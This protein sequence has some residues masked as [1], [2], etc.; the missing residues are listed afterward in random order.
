MRCWATGAMSRADDAADDTSAAMYVVSSNAPA[1]SRRPVNARPSRN[2]KRIWTPA[3]TTRTSW[4][5]SLKLRWQRAS[6]DSSPSPSSFKSLLFV[7][8]LRQRSVPDSPQPAADQVDHRGRLL[9][10]GAVAGTRHEGH[11]GVGAGGG[12]RLDRDR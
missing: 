7:A 4:S 3:C 11:V 5:S 10:V 9:E 12:R 2:A 1:W 6:S 8:S